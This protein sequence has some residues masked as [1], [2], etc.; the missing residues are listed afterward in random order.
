MRSE[1]GMRKIIVTNTSLF[2]VIR[3]IESDFSII[4][5][6]VITSLIK[7]KE[8]IFLVLVEDETMI[9]K[10]LNE[11][12]HL[13]SCIYFTENSNVPNEIKSHQRINVLYKDELAEVNIKKYIDNLTLEIEKQYDTVEDGYDEDDDEDILSSLANQDLTGNNDQ[14]AVDLPIYDETVANRNINKNGLDLKETNNELRKNKEY[15]NDDSAIH[16]DNTDQQQG[17]KPEKGEKQ[18]NDPILLKNVLQT[19]SFQA[20]LEDMEFPFSVGVDE[21]GEPI[22]GCL[23]QIN[24]ILVSGSKASGKGI[25]ITQLLS[26]L[27]IK[28]PPQTVRIVLIVSKNDDLARLK[29]FPHVS[30]HVTNTEDFKR[31]LIN[32]LVEMNRRYEQFN[33]SD[34]C[35]NINEYNQNHDEK[36]DYILL[37]VHELFDDGVSKDPYIED[38]LIKLSHEGK[39]VG[40]ILL[41]STREMESVRTFILKA[42]L[43]SRILFQY[44]NEQEYQIMFPKTTAPTQELKNEDGLCLMAGRE[45]IERFQG[46]MISTSVEGT[47]Q[48]INKL[49]DDLNEYYQYQPPSLI[50]GQEDGD[51]NKTA[52]QTKATNG[53]ET[54]K[55]TSTTSEDKGASV[56]EANNSVK[57]TTDIRVDKLRQR[58]TEI[59]RASQETLSDTNKTIGLWSPIHQSGQ[60]HFSF[61]FAMFLARYKVSTAVIEAITSRPF[62]GI[63]LNQ[64]TDTPSE[65]QSYA[66]ALFDLTI[67]PANV[68]WLYK[69]VHWYPL[70]ESEAFYDWNEDLYYQYINGVKHHDILLVDLETGEMQ[71]H[72]LNTL[73][74]LDEVWVFITNQFVEYSSYV[75]YMERLQEEYQIPFKAVFNYKTEDSKSESIAQKLQLPLIGTLNLL[76]HEII[77]NDYSQIP[78]IEEKGVLEKWEPSLIE[79]GEYLIGDGRFKEGL[80]FPLKIKYQLEKVYSHYKP[81]KK[82]RL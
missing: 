24:H 48:V 73:K 70:N 64:F 36:M 25:W 58:V 41:I 47:Y 2:P 29:S 27:M 54:S 26:T 63:R 18:K 21:Q 55:L 3:P 69:G 34:H 56:L 35:L 30:D 43:P 16:G 81:F 60:T 71:E 4:V 62:H 6:K 14:E 68:E 45:S 46:L 12:P 44:N 82:R 67:P 77:R 11:N 78:L 28:Q 31:L 76:V 49:Q 74:H 53:D 66:D 57:D 9:A 37:C 13:Q 75:D 51:L 50:K 79:L 7:Y 23:S 59:R 8:D 52:E 22:I 1:V 33:K 19:D 65:W 40:I 32:L 20:A 38:L 10:I 5:E 72:T 39:S 15:E 17:S 80:T 61:V 42:D